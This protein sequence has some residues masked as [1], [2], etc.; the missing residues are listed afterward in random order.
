MCMAQAAPSQPAPAPEPAAAQDKTP[1]EKAIEKK[2]QSKRA[3][4]ILPQFAVTNRGD[5]PPLTPAEKF[6][7]FGKFAFDPFEFGLVGAQAGISQA[8]NQFPAYGQGAQGYG[9]RYGAAFADE[10]SSGFFSTFFWATV[11]KEDPRYFRLGEG[12]FTHRFSYALKQEIVCHT[13][14]GGRSFSW[15]NTLG[16][17]SSGGLSNVYYPRGDRGLELTASRAGIAVLYGTASGLLDEFWPDIY[18]KFHK[19]HKTGDAAT[20]T[21]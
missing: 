10:V 19:R 3:L 17:F 15:E 18:R 16:A 9:K 11:L 8:E 12:T 5:A 7:L 13:D 2:E 1:R 21:P 6:R 4:G 14:K 20:R